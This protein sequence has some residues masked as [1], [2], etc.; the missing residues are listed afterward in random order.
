M[1]T[2]GSKYVAEK[3][4][5]NKKLSLQHS[6]SAQVIKQQFCFQALKQSM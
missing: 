6:N 5:Q 4:V 1:P 2:L 3:Q